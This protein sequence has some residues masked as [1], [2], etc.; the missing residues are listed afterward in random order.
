MPKIANQA[1]IDAIEL[2]FVNLQEPNSIKTYF[3]KQIQSLDS[4]NTIQFGS[5]GGEY[6][7]AGR[8]QDGSL[9]IK[10]AD[11]STNNNFHTYRTDKAGKPLKLLSPGKKYNPKIRPWYKKAVEAK[12]TVWSPIYIMFSH[13]R[14]GITLSK[15]VYDDTD[16]GKL[17]GVI[18][19]DV[20]LSEISEFLNNLTIGKTG[21][22][23]II[24]RSELLVASSNQKQPFKLNN[25]KS[26]RLGIINSN[27]L[28]FQSTS[29]YLREN[30]GN[31]SQ[32]Q[33]SQQLKF[34]INGHNHFLQVTPFQDGK[35]LDWLIIVVV[36]EADFMGKINANTRTTI[37]LCLIALISATFGGIITSR[38]IALPILQL[39]DAATA[40]AKGDWKQK[41]PESRGRE[42]G[43]LAQAFNH[44][45]LQLQQSFA[46]LEIRV[47]ERTTALKEAN[48]HLRA[49]IIERQQAETAL[50]L[51]EAKFR[52][53]FENSQVGIFRTSIDDCSF[54]DA[55][56][57]CMEM[58][59]YSCATELIEKKSSCDI[60][61]E[62]TVREQILVQL[63]EQ[64]EVRNF[65]TQFR[66]QDGSVFWVLLSARLNL[67][68]TCLE[69]VITDISDR[70]EAGEALR[71]SEAM[72]RDLVQTANCIILR[73]D[74]S[75]R[76]NFLNDYGQSFFGYDKEN[77]LGSKVVGTMIP[78]IKQSGHILLLMRRIMRAMLG[79]ICKN[80][81]RYL[82]Y[83][84]E[85][86][87]SNGERVWVSWANKSILDE[88]GNLKEILSVG[89]DITARKQ[90]EEGLK[91]K[92]AYLR[93]I[94]DNIPQ[95]V[96][97]KDTNLVF[98]GCNKNWAEA[99]QIENPDYVVS[100]TDYDLLPHKEIA[101]L[102]REQD[103]RI[104]ETDT[105]QLHVIAKKQ[106]PAPDG[107]PIWLD[108][109]KIPIHNSKGKVI[110]VL[111]VLEDI[112]QRKLAEEALHAEREKSEA[113][114]L[115]ILPK[116]IA[117][118]LKE[119]QSAIAEHFDDVT[120]LF[121]DIVGFTPLSAKMPP[122]A[123]V[124]FLNQIFSSFDQLA[125]NHGLE[126]I[127]TIGD[128]YM[129]AGGLPIP[130]PNH[131]EA[132][133]QMA[134]DMQEAIALLPAAYG[135]RLQIRIGINTGSVVA[136]V[137]GIKKF[138]YDL[139][140]DTVNVA[141]RMESSGI[142]GFI[143][144][145]E[146]TYEHLKDKYILEERGAIAVKGKGDMIT[147]WLRGR[148]VRHEG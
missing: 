64:G 108:I 120:I 55:N 127:K 99:A 36:P 80:P 103:R 66:R 92:E 102:F 46:N 121:A 91:E 147:Y 105:P 72:Y 68:E 33:T 45:R 27:D 109:S 73:L 97:W 124:N 122:T 79:D 140:G 146:V 126:K 31:L 132:I 21:K 19:T 17:V 48:H 94:L 115:N 139:W 118:Q 28:L 70:K 26:K 61:V 25:G 40:L 22:S 65:E 119:D 104:M 62:S 32:I 75:G 95:Q 74:T 98:L 78:E 143:Q 2:D 116:A 93:L 4:I 49:E 77:V 41:I 8:W 96:F 57:R 3:L 42:V 137:I 141:S 51:S 134:L 71:I 81:D 58:L 35:G 125:E 16:E 84:L 67:E 131:A 76:V 30:F 112:T 133:A 34:K 117:D 52:N 29:E 14:L 100:K 37:Q 83:E 129:V 89:T 114:L 63:K 5:E 69:G 38:W 87:C 113:L 1:A 50:R 128:A 111:G 145:T 107:E 106:R 54:L 15:P 18:G 53:L 7:G 88:E 13:G 60:Y 59:G 44:M 20:L 148:K 82:N 23:F 101:E 10:R 47:E 6:I 86:I 24:E 90:A 142:P 136:G 39:S 85:H 11:R 144:V 123:L 135:E 138:I 9:V 43:I 12:Q 56:Q 130:N 110:G